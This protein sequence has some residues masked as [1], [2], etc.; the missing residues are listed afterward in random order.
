MIQA[1]KIQNLPLPSI[2]C[3]KLITPDAICQ[4]KKDVA[5]TNASH[6]ASSSSKKQFSKS[7]KKKA[8]LKAMALLDSLSVSSGDDEDGSE[9]S[10]DAIPDPQRNL[11]GNSGFDSQDVFQVS[12]TYNICRQS[13][14]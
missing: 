7:K 14:Y 3:P 10:S 2:I 1:P 5:S 9:A 13:C 11:F 8:L 4:S 6:A 12:K